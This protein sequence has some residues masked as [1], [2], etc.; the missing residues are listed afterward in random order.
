MQPTHRKRILDALH[1][2]SVPLDDDQLAR[3]TGIGPGKPSTRSAVRSK[4]PGS[5][6]ATSGR[7]E[8]SST[9]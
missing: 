8:S 7:M 6:G 2:S 1:L 5:Y 3:R 9:N 4:G